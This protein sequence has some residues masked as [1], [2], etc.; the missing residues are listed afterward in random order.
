MA[1]TPKPWYRKDRKS[2]FVTINGKRHN[3]GSDKEEAFQEF[4]RLMA[5]PIQI[6]KI[7]V[8][9]LMD[10]FLDWTEKHRAPR[11]YEFHQERLNR[12]VKDT[13][14]MDCLKLKP[15]HVQKWLDSKDTWGPTYKSGVVSSIKRSFNWAVR[16]GYLSTNPIQFLEKPKPNKR[17]T[18]VTRDEYQALLA[19]IDKKDPFYDLVVFSWE[20]GCRPQESLRFTSSDVDEKNMRI[21]IE[22][23]KARG[24]KWR[25]IH[26]NKKALRIVKKHRME[27]GPVFLNTRGNPWTPNSCANRFDRLKKKVGRMVALYDFRHAYATDMLKNGV[28]PLTVAELMGHTNV[29][30]LMET[31]Q[32]VSQDNAYIQK[33]LAKRSKKAS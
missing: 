13:A 5:G 16:Q 14:D 19:N 24:P 17:E 29:K 30:M 8:F 11:T 22:N 27:Q 10:Q 28:D 20:T 12:F 1:R 7:S 26:L 31:Y 3:L 18:P 9:T 6:D 32:H 33:Q 4:Y 23:P 25:V 21:V 2:W 15:F